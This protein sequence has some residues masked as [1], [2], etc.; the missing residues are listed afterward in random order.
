MLRA[1]TL[2]AEEAVVMPEPN[3]SR[4]GGAS[5][6]QEASVVD[7]VLRLEEEGVFRQLVAFL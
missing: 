6:G 7:F 2:K 3:S 5:D 4:D 1:R